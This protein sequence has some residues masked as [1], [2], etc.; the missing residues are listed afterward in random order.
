MN[1]YRAP[2]ELFVDSDVLLSQE[3]TTQGDLLAMPMY[4]LATIPQIR[5]FNDSVN[6]VYQVWYADNASGAGKSTSY[7]NGGIKST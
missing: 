5:K 7:V 2:S 4:V 1:T 3:G 6:E